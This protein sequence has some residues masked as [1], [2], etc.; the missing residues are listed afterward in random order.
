MDLEEGE[1]NAS[2]N[3]NWRLV[4][5]HANVDARLDL[6]MRDYFF[7]ARLA[8]FNVAADGLLEENKKDTH[9]CMSLMYW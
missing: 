9:C 1:E 5:L 2:W 6:G 8:V 4:A 3:L 7:Q